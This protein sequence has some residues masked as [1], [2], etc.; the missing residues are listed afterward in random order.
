MDL[1]GG[2]KPNMKG[3]RSQRPSRQATP[4]PVLGTVI[5]EITPPPVQPVRSNSFTFFKDSTPVKIAP[6]AVR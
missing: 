6:Q 4:V 1:L 2:V 5:K 3:L